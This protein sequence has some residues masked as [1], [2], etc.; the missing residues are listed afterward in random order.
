[1]YGDVWSDIERN[2]GLHASGMPLVSYTAEY[3]TD[4]SGA[5]LWK[6]QLIFGSLN[7]CWGITGSWQC[8]RMIVSDNIRLLIVS[9][10]L[11]GWKPLGRL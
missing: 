9:R 8:A 6:V 1:M 3:S 11:P 2:S 7:A 4:R 5:N 10:P